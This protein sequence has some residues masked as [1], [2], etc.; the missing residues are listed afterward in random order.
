MSRSRA[1][2]ID[3]EAERQKRGE[4]E[5]ERER[6]RKREEEQAETSRR[7]VQCL[8][9]TIDPTLTESDSQTRTHRGSQSRPS[10]RCY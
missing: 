3:G 7:G 8:E 1:N 4:R 9:D 10:T 5:R 6:E 2:E